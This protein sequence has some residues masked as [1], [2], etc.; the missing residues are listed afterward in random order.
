MMDYFRKGGIVPLVLVLCALS[1]VSYLLVFS[2]K[3]REVRRLQV[4]V[5]AREAEMGSAVRLWGEMLTSEDE[6]TRRLEERARD[7]RERVPEAPETDRLM[8]EIGRRAVLHDL[9]AFRLTVPVES[10]PGGSGAVEVATAAP[11]APSASGA[12]AAAGTGQENPAMPQEV[13]LRL[14][15][16]SSYRDLAAF[17]DGIPRMKRLLSLRSLSVHE[18]DGAMESTVEISAYYGGAK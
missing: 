5:A 17:V 4:E 7:W 2:P 13:R 18:K 8:A 3:I 6:A 1:A 10:G 11:G 9:R 12:S 14:T 15:F 16:R